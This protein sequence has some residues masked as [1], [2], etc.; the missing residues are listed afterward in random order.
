M[1]IAK[2]GDTEFRGMYT[3]LGMGKFEGRIDG[4][5]YYPASLISRLYH[6]IL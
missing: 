1:G 2:I 5:R 4:S 6:V 3:F